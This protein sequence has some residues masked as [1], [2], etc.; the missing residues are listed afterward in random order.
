MSKKNRRI[1]L[2]VVLAAFVS[3]LGGVSLYS[4]L[5]PQKTTVY[6]FKDNY[7]SGTTVTKSMLTAVRCDSKIVVAGK[8]TD[9]S[10]KFVTGENLDAV[11]KTGDS[12]RMDVSTGMPLTLALL[13]VNGGSDVEK[14][15]DPKSIAVTVPISDITGVSN[16]LKNGSRVNIYETAEGGKTVLAFQGMR[17][18]STAKD[19]SGTLTSA[20]IEANK[21]QA[22]QLVN[23]ASNEAQTVYI[24]K[25]GTKATDAKTGKHSVKAGKVTIN[26]VVKYQN[27]EKGKTYTLKGT[28]MDKK[29]GK[30]IKVN[31]KEV[32][33]TA[34]FVAGGDTVSNEKDTV[35]GDVDKDAAE[36]A[37]Q[38]T[39][40]VSG[41][42]T[43]TFK[44]DASGLGGKTLVAFEHLYEGEA[45]IANHTDIKDKAQSVDII[46][47]KKPVKGSKR[48]S[49]SRGKKVQT[50][51]NMKMYIFAGA[52]VILVIAGVAFLVKGKKKEE[53]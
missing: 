16:D 52:A 37:I 48:G 22:I 19:S 3:I 9:T 6:V 46:K 13:S 10:S 49:Y 38:K 43:V 42:A 41:E 1:V 24:P 45:E 23:A 25:I 7:E 53:E 44:F 18:L 20:T 2:I 30:A 28:L 12:L 34:S 33:A 14:N 32:T 40:R 5:T 15:M 39:E 17:I 27:L 21:D 4:Y 29:T 36:D 26:D 31:G 51:D 50:G 11:L 35:V 47:V 8:N